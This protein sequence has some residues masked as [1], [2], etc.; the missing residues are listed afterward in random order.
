MGKRALLLAA[1]VVLAALTAS[2]AAPDK[3]PEG[4]L[5]G[6]EAGRDIVIAVDVS[7]SL[8]WSDPAGRREQV[9]ETVLTWVSE[10]GG[11][12]VAVMRFA[13]WNETEK[14]GAFVF[15][16][17]DDPDFPLVTVPADSAK[18]DEFLKRL[19]TAIDAGLRTFGRGSDINA[20]FEKGIFPVLEHR[21]KIRSKNNL[22]VELIADGFYDVVED[23]VRPVYVETA[24]KQSGRVD[25]ETLNN[26]AFEHFKNTIIPRF[27]ELKGCTFNVTNPCP[28]VRPKNDPLEEIRKKLG[29]QMNPAAEKRLVPDKARKHEKIEVGAK[30]D[31]LHGLHVYQGALK[32]KVII[33]TT[34]PS[35]K[36]AV[37]I[38]DPKG[39]SVLDDPKLKVLGSKLANR[40]FILSGMAPGDYVIKISNTRRKTTFF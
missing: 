7:G 2:P 33:I 22:H 36:F 18:R 6:A 10:K 29:A 28:D 14:N 39:K 25:R 24:K 12:R 19:K 32:T 20:A 31:K 5:G 35:K 8:S 4:P 38:L 11:D 16:S 21:E 17:K 34:P 23:E 26:A 37:D 9:I 1:V 27:N 3:V 30:K 13:A 15:P 40:I